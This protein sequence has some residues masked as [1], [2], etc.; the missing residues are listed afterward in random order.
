[1]SKV[2]LNTKKKHVYF[3]FQTVHQKYY[4]ETSK[5]IVRICFLF[6]HLNLGV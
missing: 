4:F 5:S 2:Y 6:N 3:A 1:M